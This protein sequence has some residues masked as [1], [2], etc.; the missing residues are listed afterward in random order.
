MEWNHREFKVETIYLEADLGLW[1]RG[2]SFVTTIQGM[3]NSLLKPFTLIKWNWENQWKTRLNFPQRGGWLV[4]QV[5]PPWI[6][7]RYPSLQ[8]LTNLSTELNGRIKQG[9]FNFE[10]LHQGWK[11]CNTFQDRQ[12]TYQPLTDLEKHIRVV[13]SSAM[14]LPRELD[15]CAGFWILPWDVVVLSVVSNWSDWWC[16]RMHIWVLT[17]SPHFIH[18]L[19]CSWQCLS[20][21]CVAMVAWQEK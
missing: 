2:D 1:E 6:H 5:N 7:L 13:K 9:S 8:C 3:W 21:K 16:Q 4:T 17:I 15:M 20:I 14:I 11:S 12:D 19:T 10:V 18:C